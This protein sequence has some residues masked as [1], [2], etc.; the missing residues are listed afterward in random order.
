MR[1][2]QFAEQLKMVSLVG[3]EGRFREVNGIYICDLLSWVMSHA[4]SGEAWITI[5]THI[6]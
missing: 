4:K 3:G 6:N 2:D 5:H 1:V